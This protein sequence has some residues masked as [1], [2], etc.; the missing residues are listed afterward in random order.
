MTHRTPPLVLRRA[1]ATITEEDQ[2][3]LLDACAELLDAAAFGDRAMEA[4]RRIAVV[5]R[6]LR[7]YPPMR[8]VER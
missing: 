5:M 2:E 4:R 8:R 7:V 6:R 3:A 1:I